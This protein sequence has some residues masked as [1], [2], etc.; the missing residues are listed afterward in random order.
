MLQLRDDE[1]ETFYY[2]FHFVENHVNL[3]YMES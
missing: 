2:V 3:A 1:T